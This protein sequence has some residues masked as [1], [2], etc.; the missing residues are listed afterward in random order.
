MKLLIKNDYKNPEDNYLEIVER[1]G[2]G[3]PDTLADKLAEE[4]SRVYSEYCINK[5]GF[6]LH[7]NIDKLYIGAGLFLLENG[8]LYKVE[9][10]I[11]RMSISPEGDVAITFKSG[12]ARNTKYSKGY[13]FNM[14]G[15]T[16]SAKYITKEIN[17][18]L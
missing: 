1:K 10:F 5:Y 16:T 11:D 4:C 18:K 13:I 14:A 12:Y 17:N 2:M 6:I 9:L 7:H 8:K 15:G 3:H